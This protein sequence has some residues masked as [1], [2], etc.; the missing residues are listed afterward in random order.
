MERNVGK[1]SIIF[2]ALL[3][4]S[5]VYAAD[6]QLSEGTE[7]ELV[8]RENSSIFMG[9]DYNFTNVTVYGDYLELKNNSVTN[10]LTVYP[11]N[12]QEINSTLNKYLLNNPEPGTVFEIETEANSPVTVT[13]EVDAKQLSSGKYKVYNDTSDIIETSD[14]SGTI[15]WSEDSWSNNTF[16]IEYT[17]N[18]VELTWT[19]ESDNEEQFNVYSNSSSQSLNES[20]IVDRDPEITKEGVSGTGNTLNAIHSA[21]LDSGEYVCYR[22]TA[23]NKYGESDPTPSNLPDSNA[24]LTIP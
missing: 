22:V 10:N 14:G 21:S 20:D 23:Q 13:Y 6:V 24:C 8:D 15:T 2:I 1:F 3:T 7:V 4:L 9:Q 11:S 17:G 18:Q 12:T 5:L 16:T 19:D